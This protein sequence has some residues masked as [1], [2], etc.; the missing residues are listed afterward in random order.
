M[1][2]YI[3]LWLKGFGRARGPD[4]ATFNFL[5]FRNPQINVKWRAAGWPQGR[6]TNLSRR[7]KFAYIYRERERESESRERDSLFSRKA[8]F[9]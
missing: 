9:A 3:K 4:L 7:I 2:Q 6:G 8:A 5:A 1:C